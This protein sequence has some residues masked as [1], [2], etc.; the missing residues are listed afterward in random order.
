M[1]GPQP[2]V[3]R[4]GWVLLLLTLTYSVNLMDRQLLPMLAQSIKGEFEL[5]D[6]TLGLLSG[7]VFALFYMTVAVPVAWLADRYN[8]VRIIALSCLAWSGFTALSGLCA[9]AWQLA[10]AR[11]G[12][13]IGEAGGAAPSYALVADYFPQERRARAMAILNMGLPIGIGGGIL[14]AGVV[15]GAYGWR[16]A[17]FV[18]A[19]PGAILSLLLLLTV[20][21]PLRGAGSA[22]ARDPDHRPLSLAESLRCF[23]RTPA[24]VRTTIATALAAAAFLGLTAWMPAYLMRVL[25][26]SLQ[27]V[28]FYYSWCS[29]L[30]M[31]GGLW[32]GGVLADRMARRDPRHIATVPAIGLFLAAPALSLMLLVEQWQAAIVLIILPIGCGLFYS[33]PAT[34]IIQNAAPPAARSTISALYLFIA[35]IVGQ[36][37]GPLFVG[38]VSDRLS[39]SHGPAGLAFG[40]WA[41]MPLF[42]AAGFAFLWVG[43]GIAPKPA[44]K[45]L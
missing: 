17:F 37:G 38:Y 44:D 40:L 42:L 3:R 35:N 32:L 34:A 14:L 29:A 2:S 31:A 27:Q 23:A 10:L 12:V 33:G 16:T 22:A 18:A 7:I 45:G 13:G 4:R 11:I 6:T 15:G 9:N 24:L 8:R 5:S 41:L 1:N 36:G 28:G 30:G 20:T 26:M 39:P 19:V 21:D 43:R 25:G